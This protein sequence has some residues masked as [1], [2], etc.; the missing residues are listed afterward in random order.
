[1]VA[2]L[3]TGM[4]LF[5][6]SASGHIAGIDSGSPKEALLFGA[7][8][9]ATD[10]V[11]TLAVLGSLNVDAQLYALVFGESVLNDAVAIV[12]FQTFDA[13]PSEATHFHVSLAQVLSALSRFVGIGLGSVVTGVVFG[14]AAALVTK[15]LVRKAPPPAEVTI[16]LAVA[17]LSFIAAD[18]AGLSGLMAVFFCGIVMSHYVQHNLSAEGRRTT[19]NVARTLAHLSEQLT[20]LYFGFTILPMVVR[21]CAI[22]EQ[23]DPYVLDFH[24]VGWTLLLCFISRAAHVSSPLPAP[25]SP[26]ARR[27]RRLGAL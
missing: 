10:P 1:V 16:M 20:F 17:Y 4:S 13:L 15:R 23:A 7:L 14:L 3:I 19:H 5:G 24:L 12:L 6:L 11:A 8:L 26:R 18:A 22:A 21:S 2:A 25:T 27:R 9:S